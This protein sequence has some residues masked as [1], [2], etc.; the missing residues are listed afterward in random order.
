MIKF[1][2]NSKLFVIGNKFFSYAFFVN[3]T[4]ILQHL[5][6]GIPQATFSIKDLTN[7]DVDWS[8]TYFDAKTKTEKVYEHFYDGRSLV[9]IAP[10]GG[11]D[12]R[13]AQFVIEQDNYLLHS[14]FIYISHRI[15]KGK[16]RL[17]NLPH[18]KDE[19]NQA[20]TLEIT[21]KLEEH[22][23]NLITSYTIYENT[24]ALLR[25][26]KLVNNGPKVILRRAY[27]F[28]L[29]LPQNDYR[30]MHFHG[31]WLRERQEVVEP[32]NHGLKRIYSNLGRS[33]HEQNPFA[34]LLREGTNEISGEC[35]AFSFV[36]SGNFSFDF[37]IDKL[38]SLR[39]TGGINDENFA[40]HLEN[41]ETFV[42]P[43]ALIIYSNA[44]CEKLTHTIH[45]LIRT[46]LI[47]PH[48]QNILRP[49][50][51]N[52]WEGFY[53]D[54]DTKKVLDYIDAIKGMGIEL[55][56]LDDGWFGK[57]NDDTSGLGDWH[58]NA[59]KI[60]LKKV[61]DAAHK[62]DL[63]FGI[64]F[65][66]EMISYD[67][68]LFRR[69]PAYALGRPTG[70]RPLSRHQ[71]IL[72]LTST[73][74]INN[75]YEQ[76][77]TIL[78]NYPINYVKWDHN[79]NIYDAFSSLQPLHK[80]GH[81]YHELMLGSYKLLQMI[82][83][84]Y[85]HIL[86]ESCASGGG[87]FDLGMLYYMPQV[88]TSDEM[89]PLQ[90]L[91]IQYSTSRLYPLSTA[92][93]HIGKHQTSSY[94]TKAKIALFGVYGLELDPRTLNESDKAAINE[95]TYL[96]K[97]HR[98]TTLH[99][100]DVYHLRNPY[101]TNEMAI[102][103]VSKDQSTALVLF[104]TIKQQNIQHRSLK[105]RGLAAESHYFNSLT[106]TVERGDYYMNIGLNFSKGNQF[107]ETYIIELTKVEK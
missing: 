68:D 92:G 46:N 96:Y 107:L 62:N 31:D 11:A 72:D 89:D 16:P 51:L 38:K 74:V 27:S 56:V 87:R 41:G 73:E 58:I 105:L 93:S 34:F 48:Q 71:F 65:E 42:V 8:K 49:V 14:E 98:E 97:K 84:R 101:T 77:I 63:K 69:H 106:N 61:I 23:L 20:M 2:E 102:M 4:G 39:V 25:N 10:F 99:G 82:T 70:R 57:R 43:E 6:Y 94:L 26:H 12:K 5:Y 52:S 86:F 90:R 35:F 75:I 32:L 47:P 76:M 103:S 37:N 66:P 95:I 59:T 29:D 7:L 79:R 88:W 45:D 67:S 64:W 104:S 91:Y 100:G 17:T 1:D 30:L 85:P 44:G 21:L 83:E 40:W 53:M 22:D 54:F 36:Y 15:Y 33:S 24:R 50:L 9:E 3:E 78:D 55:F 13:G 19:H 80:Q 28:S 60:D 18:F 81:V